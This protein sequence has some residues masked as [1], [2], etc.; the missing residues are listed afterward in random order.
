MDI[1]FGLF[2]Y[3]CILFLIKFGTSKDLLG[4]RNSMVSP[5][6]GKPMEPGGN[7]PLHLGLFH[8]Y[9][10]CVALITIRL[11]IDTQITDN[12]SIIIEH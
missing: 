7:F 2:P 1:F 10:Q 11:I 3:F 5:I 4:M 6:K 8:L 9:I 12:I